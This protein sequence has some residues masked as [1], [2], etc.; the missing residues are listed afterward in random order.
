MTNRRKLHV[1]KVGCV[2]AVL[3]LLT[4][5]NTGSW[6]T[7]IRITASALD[8]SGPVWQPGGDT[9]AYVKVDAGGK[10]QIGGV[11]A[12]SSNERFLGTG[13]GSGSSGYAFSLSWVGAGPEL[14]TNERNNLHEYLAFNTSMAPFNRTLAD[15]TDSAN[16]RQLLIAPTSGGD[17]IRAS[18][19]GSTVIWR[20]RDPENNVTLRTAPYTVMAGQYTHTVGTVALAGGNEVGTKGV[21]L[22]PDGSQY[23]ISMPSGAL[24]GWDLFLGNTDGS[25]GLSQITTSGQTSGLD[26]YSPDISPDG[27]SIIFSGG[28]E[29]V[30]GSFDLF[31]IDITGSNLTQFTNTPGVEEGGPTWAPNGSDFAFNRY[32]TGLPNAEPDNWN[33]YVLP[34]PATIA[35]L[36]LGGMLLRRKRR[37]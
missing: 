31:T 35:L 15:G 24:G 30:F 27:S 14:L 12:D 4:A 10:W 26:N 25:G 36:S 8:D 13:P 19:D 2:I 7:P 28:T 22:S 6:A 20:H 3:S 18:R 16:V 11:Q 9:I 5:F 29:G 33:I 37:K 32:D 17:M 34:E 1:G 23:V 21:A